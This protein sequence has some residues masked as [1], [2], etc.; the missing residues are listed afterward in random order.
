M[1]LSGTAPYANLLLIYLLPAPSKRFSYDSNYAD[2]SGWADV[3]ALEEVVMQKGLRLQ[4]HCAAEVALQMI[5]AT[6]GTKPQ[7]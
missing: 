4:S 1:V 7:G 6:A 2:A 5:H 3:Q